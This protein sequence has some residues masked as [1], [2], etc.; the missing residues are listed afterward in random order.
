MS[1]LHRGL[2]LLLLAT[3]MAAPAGA[4]QRAGKVTGDPGSATAAYADLSPIDLRGLLGDPPAPNSGVVKGE[5][6]RIRA[7]QA[8]ATPADRARILSEEKLA[9]AAFSGVLG[10]ELT[11]KAL[12]AT[13][14]LLRRSARDL[15]SASAPAKKLWARRRPPLEDASIVPLAKLPSGGSYPSRHAATGRLWADIL[16]RLMPERAA[17]LAARGDQI[18]DDRVAAGVHFPS[19]VAA[20]RK[21]G[22]AVAEQLLRSDRFQSDFAK[23]RAELVAAGAAQP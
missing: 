6:D 20:G 17:A 22:D 12:P 10:A 2:V 8:G 16:A 19:D 13:E 15:T 1:S 4:G 23:A 21:L 5:L 14:R 18:G 11:R 9:P 3:W 7:A